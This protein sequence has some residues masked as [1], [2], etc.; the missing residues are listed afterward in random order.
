MVDG[1]NVN[2]EMMKCEQVW[3]EISNYADGEVESALRSAMEEHFRGCQHCTSVLEGMR[4]VV[5]LYGDERMLEVPVGF[6]GRLESR[7]EKRIAKDVREERSRWSTWSA[8]LVPVAALAL[9]AGGVRLASSLTYGNA[10]KVPMAQAGQGIPPDL[11]VL[12]ATGT[13][14]FH[15]AGC[16][17]I[18][19]KDEVR[20][21]TAKEAIAAGYVPC[22]RCMR[23]YLDVARALRER[24][25]SELTE[26]DV[27]EAE[28]LHAGER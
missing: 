21:I 2:N 26:V 25:A 5:A 17:F 18:H 8:W 12:V 15:V 20:S 27:I 14:V 7:L 28:D 3:P 22:L 1:D 4:N 19:N 11:V 6:S 9:I 10:L 16:P 24:K 23:K 13:R